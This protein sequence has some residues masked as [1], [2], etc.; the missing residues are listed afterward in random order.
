MD[1]L[2]VFT[3]VG[4]VY[5]ENGWIGGFKFNIYLQTHKNVIRGGELEGLSFWFIFNEGRLFM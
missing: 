5:G 1:D 3:C 2:F 4:M